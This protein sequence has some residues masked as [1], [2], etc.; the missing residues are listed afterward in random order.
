M[1]ITSLNAIRKMAMGQSAN[2][3]TAPASIIYNDTSTVAMMKGVNGSE[4]LTVASN[5]GSNVKNYTLNIGSTN[6]T[7]NEQL[8][9]LFDCS[10]VTA[11]D[12]GSLAIPM[13]GLPKVR[14]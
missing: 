3:T 4:L 12:K 11:G 14:D 5:K 13:D 8:V 9:Q 6:Y 1:H 7:S 2:F 10:V